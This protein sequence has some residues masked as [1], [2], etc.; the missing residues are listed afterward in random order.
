MDQATD[1]SIDLTKRLAGEVAIVTG[2]AGG[3][4]RAVATRLS[5]EG[6]EVAILDV[7]E[8]GA[9]ATASALAAEG[10]RAIGL[11]CNVTRRDEVHTSIEAVVT[12]FGRLTVLVNNAGVGRRAPFLE[13]TD[14]TWD[15]VLG[16]NLKGAFIVAQ[17]AARVM[18]KSGSGRI[19]NM[20]SVVAEIAHSNQTAYSVSK[21]GIAA[22]TRSMAFELAPLGITVNAVTP[23]TI[24]T[25]FALGSLPEIGQLRRLGRIPLGRF[26]TAA[27]VAAAVAFL[28][29]PDAAYVT[30]AMLR[31]DG[32]LVPGGVRDT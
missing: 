14:E 30:G 31:I 1:A 9:Q 25:N 8:A 20:A 32:G 29:S 7:N 5:R 16:V 10:R 21:A 24:A 27:E 23:G 28:A 11:G 12:H 26:G 18:A 17:E 4:G 19:V 15:D 6:A 3:I 2:G 22:M 13:L